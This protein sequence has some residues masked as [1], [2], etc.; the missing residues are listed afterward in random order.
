MKN[1]GGHLSGAIIRKNSKN[2]GDGIKNR[3]KW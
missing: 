2:E 3:R 1:I